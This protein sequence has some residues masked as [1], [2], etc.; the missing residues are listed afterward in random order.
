MRVTLTEKAVVRDFLEFADALAVPSPTNMPGWPGST[1][2][3]EDT[4]VDACNAAGH[5]SRALSLKACVEL[6]VWVGEYLVVHDERDAT[7]RDCSRTK[8]RAT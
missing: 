3:D 7:H 2:R 4:I 5:T 8:R 6:L 1:P